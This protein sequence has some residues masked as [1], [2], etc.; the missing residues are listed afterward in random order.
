MH[1]GDNN[2]GTG[3]SV[4]K[5]GSLFQSFAMKIQIP[6]LERR[7]Y[8]LMVKPS[9]RRRIHWSLTQ[10]AAATLKAS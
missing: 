9:V 1:E 8:V 3:I 5:I 4:E 6:L 10:P 7:V 2:T